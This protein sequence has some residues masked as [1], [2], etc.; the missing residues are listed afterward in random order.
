MELD[1]EPCPPSRT[2]ARALACCLPHT[3]RS[4]AGGGV[5]GPWPEGDV[6]PSAGRTWGL[7]PEL[8]ALARYGRDLWA[9][10]VL[11]PRHVGHI[12]VPL[13]TLSAR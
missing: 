6:R 3:A 1:G 13:R 4:A 10:H 8:H 7:R 9:P 2:P 11:L 5:A 12:H